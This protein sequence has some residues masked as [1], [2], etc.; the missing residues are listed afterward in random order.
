MG[1]ACRKH[2]IRGEE[3]E[4]NAYRGLLGKP[5]RKIPLGKHICRWKNNIKM[6]HR[7]IEWGDMDWIN[8]AHER[9]Q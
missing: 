6:V 1:R 2:F 9:D 5:V 3:D 7:K 4:E 8:L